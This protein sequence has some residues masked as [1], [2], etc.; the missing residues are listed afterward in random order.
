MKNSA[1]WKAELICFHEET[2][3]VEFV[4]EWKMWAYRDP[5]V[6]SLSVMNLFSLQIF[7]IADV[8]HFWEPVWMVVKH[9]AALQ[10]YT[11][12][13]ISTSVNELITLNFKGT[14]TFHTSWRPNPIRICFCASIQLL[15]HVWFQLT[16]IKKVSSP[17]CF[18]LSFLKVIPFVLHA[19][20]LICAHNCSLTQFNQ[21]ETG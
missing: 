19:P 8:I 5:L 11:G 21:N 7:P 10:K 2:L 3:S 16:W 17:S 6:G 4:D 13:T 1:A 15:L 12:D 14:G 18:S 20:P 9:F